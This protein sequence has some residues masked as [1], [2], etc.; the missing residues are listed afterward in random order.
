MIDMPFILP[1]RF[2]SDYEIVDANGRVIFPT[3]LYRSDTYHIKQQKYSGEYVVSL[4]NNSNGYFLDEK[5]EWKKLE[6]I[7]VHDNNSNGDGLHKK[8]GKFRWLI[9]IELQN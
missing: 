2:T 9:L 7:A 8:R 6:D 4:I 1:I 5:N 3:I